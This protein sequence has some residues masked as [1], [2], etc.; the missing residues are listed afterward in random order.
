[1]PKP[2]ND[3]SFNDT[4]GMITHVNHLTDGWA[5]VLA[6][7]VT[8]LVIFVIMHRMGYRSSQCF[9]VGFFLG[10]FLSTFWWAA[11]L[12]SGNFV[13]LFLLLTIASAIYA[14]FDRD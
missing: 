9:L 13:V 10:F 14:E 5:T 1:M 4:T 7:I 6:S 2:F 12:L 11:G 3:P 8:P